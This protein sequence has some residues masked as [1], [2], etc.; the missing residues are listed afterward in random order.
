[1]SE[2]EPAPLPRQR[3]DEDEAFDRWRNEHPDEWEEIL[4]R[5][6]EPPPVCKYCKL[7]VTMQQPNG[8]R[9]V[10]GEGVTAWHLSCP[11]KW[12][13]GDHQ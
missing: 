5:K 12:V 10:P 4:G 13:Q 1:M 2:Y 6:A 7:P 11:T 8:W 3:P 9:F